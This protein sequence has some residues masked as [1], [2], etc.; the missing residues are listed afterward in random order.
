MRKVGRAFLLLCALSGSVRTL[1]GDDRGGDKEAAQAPRGY[2]SPQEAFQARRA[3]IA[4]RDWRTS[5]S[6]M[7][8]ETQ[9]QAV[10]EI[11]WAWLWLGASRHSRHETPWSRPYPPNWPGDRWAVLESDGGTP[12]DKLGKAAREATI[13]KV[14]TMTKTHGLELQKFRAEYEKRFAVDPLD[15]DKIVT[16][17]RKREMD[18]RRAYWK[19]HPEERE[20]G[21]KLFKEHPEYFGTGITESQP[22]ERLRP[23]LLEPDMELEARVILSQ[24]IDKAGFY[25][26]AME[27]LKP[28]VE[29]PGEEDYV[30]GDLQGVTVS[31]DTAR[32]WVVCHSH[33]H[34]NGVRELVKPGRVLCRF[35]RLN[36]RWYNDN[37]EGDLTRYDGLKDR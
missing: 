5:F 10:V 30:F 15:P 21:E 34:I 19:E 33:I 24:L 6:S 32:G 36:G 4:R 2:S 23:G 3:A 29:Q 13:A 25:E 31:G 12:W 17:R 16:E 18:K 11:A 35:R 26:E 14:R 7:T 27:L 22:C 20:E 28:K 37:R 8:P 1:A 9:E